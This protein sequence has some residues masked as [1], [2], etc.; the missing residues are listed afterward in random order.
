MQITKFNSEVFF[1]VDHVVTVKRDDLAFLHEAAERSDRRR[2]RLCAH[3]GAEETLHEMIV[4]LKRDAYMIPDKHLVKVES[5]HIIEGLADVV[6]YDDTGE[7][8]DVVR[9]GDYASGRAFYFRVRSP[10]FYHSLIVRSDVLIY[11]ETATGPFRK[12]DTLAAPWAPPESDVAGMKAFMQDL[13]R[14]VD[15][16][17]ATREKLSATN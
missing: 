9:L 13:E 4:V 2:S 3:K 7:I 16:F 8:T 1:A 14:R 15:E 11:H 10:N 6:L 5:Y 12:S 17:L